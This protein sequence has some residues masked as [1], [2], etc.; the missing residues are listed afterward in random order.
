[1]AR[2]GCEGENSSKGMAQQ[3]AICKEKATATAEGKPPDP[4]SCSRDVFQA[5]AIRRFTLGS[6]SIF[7]VPAE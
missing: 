3:P 4:P 5:F 6:G 2:T 1:M 7:L